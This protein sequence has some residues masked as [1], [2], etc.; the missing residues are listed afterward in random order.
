MACRMV[1][2][3]STSSMTTARSVGSAI[4]WAAK[5]AYQLG[6]ASVAR[7]SVIGLTTHATQSRTRPLPPCSASIR[8]RIS[9]IAPECSRTMARIRSVLVPK[10]KPTAALLPWPAASP[11]W[12]LETAKTPRSANRRSATA[13]IMPRVCSARIEW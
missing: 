13:M 2:E 5:R 3:S 1:G 6:A 7:C 4:S 11:S 9:S 8:R 10:W 12:R